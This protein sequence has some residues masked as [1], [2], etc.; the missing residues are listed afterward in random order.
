MKSKEV[1]NLLK[2]SRV[3]LMNYVKS[4]KIKVTRLDN[5]YYDYDDKSVF[6]ILKKDVRTN[7]L[8]CRVSTPK[9]KK[10]LTTQVDSL[11]SYCSN[12]NINYSKIYKEIS[13]GTDLDRSELSSLIDDV[14][15]YKINT[16]YIT[17]KDRLTRLSFKTLE[18]LFLKFGTKI[19]PVLD[20]PQD[21]ESDLFDD[22]LNILHHF[23]TKTY[24]KRNKDKFD[25]LNKQVTPLIDHFMTDI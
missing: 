21:Y 5:G 14:I 15:N 7:V 1:L 8:Y 2:I 9:Q 24:S 17:H 19:V 16:I 10:Y 12:N 23:S 3:T 25:L 11:I 4:G 22:L 6:S 13:S 18:Q 20:S